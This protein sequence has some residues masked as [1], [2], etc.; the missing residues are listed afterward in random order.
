MK[1]IY[2]KACEETMALCGKNFE[3]RITG[4]RYGLSF[5]EWDALTRC[6]LR[7]DM[8]G[9]PKCTRLRKTNI[10]LRLAQAEAYMATV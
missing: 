2:E 1:S 4:S 9:T 5:L 10:E 8:Y 3:I 7:E 6:A